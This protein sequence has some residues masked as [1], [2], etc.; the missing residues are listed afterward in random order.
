M[1]DNDEKRQLIE[2]CQIQAKVVVN[3][4]VDWTNTDVW[5]YLHDCKCSSNPLYQCGFDRIGC[6][7]CPMAN[8]KRYFEF[9]RYPK[10]KEMYIKAFDRMIQQNPEHY[11]WK[12]G[13]E[14][15]EWWMGEDPN[16]MKFF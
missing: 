6:V 14:C 4:I 16:Q 10:Y 8:K 2:R 12:N 1:N 3:S 13:H 9:N 5:D 7:G 11:R 15:F